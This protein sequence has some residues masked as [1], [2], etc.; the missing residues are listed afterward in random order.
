[1]VV[2]FCNLFKNT[3]AKYTTEHYSVLK[4]N[5][6]L[7]HATI[8]M[9]CRVLSRSVVSDSATPWTAARLG[10]SAH[11]DSPGKNT[12]VGCHV[13]LQG[14][15]PTQGLNSGLPHCGQILYH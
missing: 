9:L 13:L 2:M 3:P 12:G 14:I 8:Q 5:E 11:R 4:R 15:F 10:S 1:M 7:V 6:I